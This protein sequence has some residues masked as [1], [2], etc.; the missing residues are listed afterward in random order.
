MQLQWP[1]LTNCA[2]EKFRPELL[3]IFLGIQLLLISTYAVESFFFAGGG[4]LQIDLLRSTMIVLDHVSQLTSTH[5]FQSESTFICFFGNIFI[6]TRDFF[7][8][9]HMSQTNVLTLFLC[10]VSSLLHVHLIIF[11]CN[12]TSF[13]FF[14]GD[15]R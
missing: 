4:V 15:L 5:Q 12:G 7:R 11:A 1:S 10:D 2:K 6:S 13:F 14:C 8:K 3:L 9:R